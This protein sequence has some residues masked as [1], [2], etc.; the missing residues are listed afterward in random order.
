MARSK[1]GSRHL[2][3][4]PDDN[5]DRRLNPDLQPATTLIFVLLSLR[6]CTFC[7]CL[8][9]ASRTVKR[10]Q[11]DSKRLHLNRTGGEVPAA[12]EGR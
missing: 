9:S 3:D 12:W 11:C 8:D 7:N 6:L 5:P 10:P 2:K 4:L 1:L